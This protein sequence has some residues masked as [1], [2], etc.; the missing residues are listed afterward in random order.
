LVKASPAI[1]SFNAGAG[2]AYYFPFTVER[3]VEI[4]LFGTYIVTGVAASTFRMGIYGA[5]Q[6][7]GGLPFEPIIVSGNLSSATSGTQATYTPPSPVTLSPGYT[8]YMYI[9]AS[10]GVTFRGV[11]SASGINI[12]FTSTVTLAS[13][14]NCY[15]LANTYA[16]GAPADASASTILLQNVPMITLRA[17]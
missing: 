12:G 7:F 14:G 8:Y 16:S 3:E 4:D 17:Q 6:T 15:R 9:E 1:A 11:A 5:T 13:F 2:F 10:T